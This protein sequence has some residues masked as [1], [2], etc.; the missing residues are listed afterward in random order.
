MIK[1]RPTSWYFWLFLQVIF[2]V[3]SFW[4]LSSDSLWRII[5]TCS[6]NPFS[7]AIFLI[8]FDFRWYV[9]RFIWVFYIGFKMLL[10]KSTTSKYESSIT[11]Y[12]DLQNGSF[13]L[14]MFSMST[15]IFS[16][17]FKLFFHYFIVTTMSFFLSLMSFAYAFIS[18]SSLVSSS[19]FS[20]SSCNKTGFFFF[21]KLTVSLYFQLH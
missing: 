14:A 13:L 17:Y 6:Y 4:F 1:I 11:S 16:W 12:I 9:L 19:T 20:S 18:A 2:F 10:G 8:C 15:F 21:L 3:F 5:T 7:V